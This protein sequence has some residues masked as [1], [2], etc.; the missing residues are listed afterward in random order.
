MGRLSRINWAALTCIL[1]S[2]S[3][4]KISYSKDEV[5]RRRRDLKMLASLEDCSAGSQQKLEES[6][7]RL[8]T[9]ATRGYGLVDILTSAQ[10]Y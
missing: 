3:Q 4:R 7:N 9:R 10:L 8:S 2:G 6:R 5:I 1:T